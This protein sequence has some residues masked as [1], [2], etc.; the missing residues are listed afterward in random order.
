MLKDLIRNGALREGNIQAC[1]PGEEDYPY[2]FIKVCDTDTYV[3]DQGLNPRFSACVWI[4]VFPLDH[5][6]DNRLAYRACFVAQMLRTGALLMET[7]RE[8]LKKGPL[9]RAVAGVLCRLLGGYQKITA[10]LD[11]RGKAMDRRY[12]KSGHLGNGAW[13]FPKL[14]KDYFTETEVKPTV[15]HLFEDREFP[16]PADYDGYLTHFYG[17]YMT[18]PPEE[19]RGTHHIA[20]YRIEE[21]AQADAR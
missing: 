13:A 7:G 5:Y 20:A 6:P 19:A 1:L 8:G 12:E 17:D 11:R 2:P 4:D 16:I 9:M 14:G 15:M 3:D 18:L 10:L 21:T